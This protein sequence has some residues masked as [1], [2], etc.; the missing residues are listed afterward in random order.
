MFFYLSKILLFLANPIIWIFTLLV[1]GSLTK[2]ILLKKKLLWAT[3]ICF[4]FFSNGFITSEFVRAYEETTIHYSDIQQTYDVAIVLGGFS[5]EDHEQEMVQFFSSTD[6]LMAGIKLYKTGKAKKIMISS[7]SGQI[8]KPDEREA[9]FIKNYLLEI[10]IPEEDLIIESN[11]KNTYEN[12]VFSSDI[13]NK[14]YSNGNYLLITSAF[15][16]PRAKRCFKK[17]GLNITPFSVDH[18]A[19]PRKLLVDHLFI[20]NAQNLSLWQMLIKEWIGFMAYYIM[21]YI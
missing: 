11:S 12:A 6:R 13:L 16:M 19:G 21:G 20:P 15:H 4:Y 8:M 17:V 9:L 2:N 10:G 3:V 5:S 18:Q 1:W 14:K 7:G